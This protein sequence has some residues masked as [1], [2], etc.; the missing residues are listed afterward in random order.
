MVFP[1][2]SH[3]PGWGG[4][5]CRGRELTQRLVLGCGDGTCPGGSA[6]PGGGPTG[7]PIGK[8]MEIPWKYH[9]NVMWMSCECHVNWIPKRHQMTSLALNKNRPSPSPVNH[10]DGIRLEWEYH[11]EWCIVFI[12]FFLDLMFVCLRDVYCFFFGNAACILDFERAVLELSSL[13]LDVWCFT[14]TKKF[15]KRRRS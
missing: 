10:L 7:K 5:E 12:L 9:V 3:G 8:P 11:G 2:S 14:R 15:S 4:A 6:A 1:W 13:L